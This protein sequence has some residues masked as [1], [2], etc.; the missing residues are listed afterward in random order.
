MKAG[1]GDEAEVEN[2]KQCLLGA[3]KG[4]REYAGLA[5]AFSRKYRLTTHGFVPRS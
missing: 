5:R 1:N 2:Q 4:D 3:M